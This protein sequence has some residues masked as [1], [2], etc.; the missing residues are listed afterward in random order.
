MIALKNAADEGSQTIEEK[1]GGET[2]DALLRIDP[3]KASTVARSAGVARD[4]ATRIERSQ[5][6][7]SATKLINVPVMPSPAIGTATKAAPEIGT[8]PATR[9]R[10]GGK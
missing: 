3:G 8:T 9:V 5:P 10:T 7:S 4:G 1:D 2:P 6:T